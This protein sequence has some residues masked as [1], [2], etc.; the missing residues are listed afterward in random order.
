MLRTKLCTAWD[1]LGYEQQA[2][3]RDRLFQLTAKYFG[4]VLVRRKVFAAIAVYAFQAIP[5]VWEG[6][7]PDCVRYFETLAATVGAEASQM[8][9]LN[10]L[11]IIIEEYKVRILTRAQRTA[12]SSELTCQREQMLQCAVRG[13][14]CVSAARWR[15]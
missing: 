3:F 4:S 9:L 15:H 6:V 7:V 5:D 12:V 11:Q 2:L 1:E 10:L 14:A 13:R 8:L